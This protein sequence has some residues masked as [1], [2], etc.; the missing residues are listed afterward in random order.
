MKTAILSHAVLSIV[1][2]TA[3]ATAPHR[4]R[5]YSTQYKAL[6]EETQ[7]RSTHGFIREGDSYQA[8]YIAM[9]TPQAR[10]KVRDDF[11][12]FEE[13]WI[14]IGKPAPEQNLLEPGNY[15][16]ITANDIDW[17][18]PF[19]AKDIKRIRVV[20]LGE[21]VL[22]VDVEENNGTA[23]TRPEMVMPRR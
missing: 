17:A 22:R 15:R 7:K 21:T 13:H 4:A 5:Q 14:Y 3:C 23:L 9:G 1:L 2:L 10:E 6:P 19:N 20:F 8:V 16:F 12:I 18:N 11:G